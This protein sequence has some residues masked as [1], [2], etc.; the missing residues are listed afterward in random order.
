[1]L[2]SWFALAGL[3][4]FVLL[5]ARFYQRFSGEL[6]YFPLFALP[7]VLFGAATVRYAS[8]DQV[9]GDGLADSLF[10]T[11][12]IILMVMCVFLYHRMTRNR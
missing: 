4:V 6:T 10:A 1:M 5:I 2:Y 3:L 11:G 12:G 9:A 8:I 7:I